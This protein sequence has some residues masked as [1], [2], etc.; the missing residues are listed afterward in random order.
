MAAFARGGPA[1][2]RAL[3]SVGQPRHGGGSAAASDGARSGEAREEAEGLARGEGVR[4]LQ[5]RV[6]GQN[7]L[8][9]GARPA[10]RRSSRKDE[11]TACVSH[12][13]NIHIRILS[14][15]NARLEPAAPAAA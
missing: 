15:M 1:P 10:C 14:V 9:R 13:Y 8:H 11:Y 5:V 12:T 3:R 7:G 2:R 6:E 4:G